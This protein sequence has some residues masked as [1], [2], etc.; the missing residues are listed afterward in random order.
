MI[1]QRLKQLR[2]ARGLTLDALAAELGGLVT[3]QALSKYEQGSM[4]PSPVVLNKLAATL[5]VKAAYLFGEPSVRVEF[6]AYRKVASLPK[7]EQASIEGLVGHELEER[8]RLQELV[9][10]TNGTD[11][12]VRAL[13]VGT[14]DDAERAAEWVR[15]RWRLGLDPI[16]SV[17]DVLEEHRIHVLEIDASEKFDGIAAAAYDDDGQVAAAAVVTRR[18]VPGERQRLSLCHEL[19]HL[20]LD[21]GEA[22]DEEKAAFRF[23]S[24]FLAPAPLI[25][26]EIGAKRA[27]IWPEE[28][29]LQKRRLGLSAQALLYRMR[30]LGIIT[31]SYYR[32]WC[33]DINRLGWRK[34]EPDAAPAERPQW[35]RKAVLRTLAEGLTT[36]EEAESLLGEAVDARLPLSLV[37]RRALAKLPLEERRRLLQEQADRIE[38][39]Y[40]RDS[41]HLEQGETDLVEY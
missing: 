2:L 19:G 38:D 13:R 24:A 36:P 37:Q 14:L 5:G 8:I 17:V 30:D 33:I 9:Q 28:L 7:R 39:H 27:H 10:Q 21:V 23:G 29:L 34:Q 6:I 26:R 4:R 25:Y 35:L 41:D 11:L 20:V 12:P 1:G 16:A 40:R 31:E 18:G 22:V 15:E 3:K 32:R